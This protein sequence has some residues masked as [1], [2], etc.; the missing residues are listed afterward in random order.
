MS[1]L[2]D[3]YVW[4]VLRAVPET[5]RADL[6]PE[7][8]ALIADA[9][10]ARTA[11]GAAESDDA[12]EHFVLTE[13]GDPEALAARYTDRRLYLIGPRYYLAWKRFL[14]TILPIIVPLSVL[15]VMGAKAIGGESSIGEIVGNGVW[16]GFMVTTQ[17]AFWFTVAF[18]LIERQDLS[19]DDAGGW[20][21]D[22]LPAVPVPGRP[23]IVELALS[24][25]GLVFAAG[26]IV[27]QQ[28]A[29]PITIGGQSYP[30]FDP[31]L[32]SFWLSWF[33]VVVA[34][35]LVFTGA[36][37]LAARW[38]WRFAVINAALALAFGV[39]AVW[40]IATGR[41]WNPAA[42]DALKAAGFDGAIAPAGTIIAI[43]IVVIT[44]WDSVDGFVRA[45]RTSRFASLE[46]A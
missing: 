20:T 12:I 17:L 8:R 5:Q 18:A 28:V 35:E 30:I 44:A 40:L 42:A 32:W 24:V 34:L 38:T 43:T 25:A 19:L 9:V 39:P 46:K 45:W 41:L 2:T 15:S 36:T 6:E 33:L 11:G 14:L 22:R 7:I 23:S 16:V 4:A 27:W 21:P 31:A 10:E 1:T 13:L 26:F 29:A 37:Y 3:R